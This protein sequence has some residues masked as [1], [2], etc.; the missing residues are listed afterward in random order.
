MYEEL[1]R[2]EW[3]LTAV[4]IRLFSCHAG[5]LGTTHVF[6]DE[7]CCAFPLE[8]FSAVR[9]CSVNLRTHE[10]SPHCCTGTMRLQEG[11]TLPINTRGRIVAQNER[12]HAELR[13]VVT[14]S[15]DGTFGIS[16]IVDGPGEYHIL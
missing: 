1:P 10:R 15:D 8:D 12:V 4:W 11:A 7:S 16:F 13:Q 2:L 5:D 14:V 6:I 3:A 9:T